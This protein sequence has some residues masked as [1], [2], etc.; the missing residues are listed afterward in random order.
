MANT[1]DIEAAAQALREAEARL[2]QTVAA[3]VDGGVPVTKAAAAADVTRV[4]IY[5]WLETAKAPGPQ[6]Q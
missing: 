2:H 5:R 3:A 6:E 4:T 1:H